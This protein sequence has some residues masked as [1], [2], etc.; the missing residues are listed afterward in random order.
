[1]SKKKHKLLFG[2]HISIA[3]GLD[4]VFEKGESLGFT[5]IQ[6]FSKSNRQWKSKKISP[7]EI[8]KFK[9]AFKKSSI[10]S[11]FVHASYLINIGSSKKE[12]YQKSTEALAEELQRCQLLSLPYLIL[13]PGSRQN[14][15]EE[16]CLNLISNN[17]NEVF[18]SIKGSTA[19]LLENSSGAG[20]H[21]GYSFEQ[22]AK[23]IDKIHQKNRIGICIDTCH[24]FAAGYDISSKQT[25]EQ[26]WKNFNDIL[27]YDLLKVIHLN[28]SKKECGS[29]ID[30]HEHIGQGKI[31]KN[32]FKYLF[33]DRH[34]YN[35]PKIL[36]TPHKSLEDYIPDIKTI[37]EIVTE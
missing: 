11:V 28:D 31:G 22:L 14:S 36:E 29:R 5:T 4:K 17:I 24:A 1:M 7:E 12:I 15:T 13:H 6:I 16:E 37:M 34:L 8:E 33:N 10:E 9:Y 32:A 2:G 21:V 25:Y 30:R 20:T 18:D 26:M 27:G 35:I 3:G 23:I 19:I